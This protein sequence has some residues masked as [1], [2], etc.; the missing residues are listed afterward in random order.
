[1]FQMQTRFVLSLLSVLCSM[2]LAASAQEPLKP[3]VTPR[4]MTATRQ[5]TL[6]TDLE[7]RI[8]TSIQK[9]DAASLKTLLADDFEI[10]MPNGDPIAAEDWIPAVTGN[11]TL[12]SFRLSQM[13]ARDFGDTV[14]VKFTRDQQA[15]INGKNDSGEYFVVDVWRK[16]GESWR[17]SDRYVTKVSAVVPTNK[18]TAPKP[19]GKD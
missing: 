9:K 4:I 15:E 1:M 12:K 8:L 18:R 13:A 11:Y 6:F 5:V 17:L 10:W 14:V 16:D 2:M 7:K 19:T 3:P